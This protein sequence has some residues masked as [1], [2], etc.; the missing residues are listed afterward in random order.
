MARPDSL[1]KAIIAQIVIELKKL[2]TVNGYVTNVLDEAITTRYNDYASQ[3]FPMYPSCYVALAST[4]SEQYPARSVRRTAHFKLLFRFRAGLDATLIDQ[5]ADLE[6]D[7][8]Y[9]FSQNI[10]LVTAA[11]VKLAA[12]TKIGS[13]ETDRGLEDPDGQVVVDLE[14]VYH[15]TYS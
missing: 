12:L 9:L 2:K 10:H 6:T 7:L 4:D 15:P 14:V 3:T 8:E 11:G 13:L 1:L 5:T